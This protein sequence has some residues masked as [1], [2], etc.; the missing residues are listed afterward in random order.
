MRNYRFCLS[1]L[2]CVLLILGVGFTDSA[3]ADELDLR[4]RL[5]WGSDDEPSKHPN[6]QEVH[7]HL[8]D[9]LKKVFK[10][11]HYY[12]I[13]EKQISIADKKSKR[14]RMSDKCEVMVKNEGDSML[15]VKLWGEGKFVKKHRHPLG[16]DCLVLGGE[17]KNDTA[18]FVV[19]T[20]K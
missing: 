13:N 19:V 18:W 5:V 9:T 2:A 10:W 12:K 14:V 3:Q 20:K 11:K 6:L 7:P 1:T 15:E 8:A 17:D 4:V 16:S